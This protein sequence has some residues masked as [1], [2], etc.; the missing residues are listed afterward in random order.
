MA[1]VAVNVAR[2][3]FG[4]GGSGQ[5]EAKP[6]ALRPS[7]LSTALKPPTMGTP[8]TKPDLGNFEPVIECQRAMGAHIKEFL[9]FLSD[10][11][12]KEKEAIVV[13]NR[14]KSV[15]QLCLG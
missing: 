15:G 5:A 7:L 4:S 13:D 9:G 8:D 14:R 1:A 12:E 10:A 6:G 2:S 11:N 3:G